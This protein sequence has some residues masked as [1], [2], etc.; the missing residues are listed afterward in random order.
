[1]ENRYKLPKCFAD[2]NHVNTHDPAIALE[3]L[4]RWRNNA[5]ARLHGTR[6]KWFRELEN[7][8]GTALFQNNVLSDITPL[9]AQ[10]IQQMIRAGLVVKVA[11]GG[12]RGYPKG[13]EMKRWRPWAWYMIVPLEQRN[14][15]RVAEVEELYEIR[16]E[17]LMERRDWLRGALGQVADQQKN[18]RRRFALKMLS[19]GNSMTDVAV[20]IGLTRERIRQFKVDG[21][22][23]LKQQ[24]RLAL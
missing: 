8:V 13:I 17:A 9:G 18:Y 11:G 15:K 10:R 4:E 20:M 2:L 24:K 3:N 6:R 19:E 12:T 23:M 7:R 21:L 1:M 14:S 16:R 5:I 22:R